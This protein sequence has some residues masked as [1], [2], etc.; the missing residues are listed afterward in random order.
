MSQLPLFAET[1]KAIYQRDDGAVFN[2]EACLNQLSDTGDRPVV[3]VCLSECKRRR[4]C[5]WCFKTYIPD[6]EP[7]ADLEPYSTG[8]PPI[9]P[10]CEAKRTK[11]AD[12]QGTIS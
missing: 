3:Y 2:E 6:Y 9:C 11:N 12:E 10:E 1:A 8:T 5:W 7:E 4:L